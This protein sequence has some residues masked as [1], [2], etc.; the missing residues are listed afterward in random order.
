MTW[1]NSE[2]HVGALSAKWP[3]DDLSYWKSLRE[4]VDALRSLMSMLNDKF[5]DIDQ[6]A[7]LSPQGRKSRRVEMAK[8]ALAELNEFAPLTKAANTVARRVENLRAKLTAL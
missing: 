3:K 4:S 2:M 6:D 8:G 1:S 7:D 5:V